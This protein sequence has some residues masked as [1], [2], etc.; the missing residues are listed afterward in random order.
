MLRTVLNSLLFLNEIGA[1]PGGVGVAGRA[2]QLDGELGLERALRARGQH[3]LEE[4]GDERRVLLHW[5]RYCTLASTISSASTATH[6][7]GQSH[8]KA[9]HG[10][11][12]HVSHGSP[13]RA[14]DQLAYS[15]GWMVTWARERSRTG[16]GTQTHVS[17][18]PIALSA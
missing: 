11:T 1:N 2:G 12:M 15:A 13:L 3:G 18:T 7:Q 6:K 16:R 10:Q 14:S 8:A 4:L 5:T 17:S 9:T